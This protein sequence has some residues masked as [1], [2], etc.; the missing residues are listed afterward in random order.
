MFPSFSF[1][2]RHGTCRDCEML[3]CA[4]R[5]TEMHQN[6]IRHMF[7]FSRYLPWT[8]L[9]ETYIYISSCIFRCL[10]QESEKWTTWPS[11]RRI[12]CAIWT[13]Q[14]QWIY[15]WHLRSP[16]R[17]LREIDVG[18]FATRRGSRLM[19]PV[20]RCRLCRATRVNGQLPT[21]LGKLAARDGVLLVQGIF[22]GDGGSS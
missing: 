14:P 22:S 4:Q 20:I 5:I 21:L 12:S 13:A 18:S 15:Q 1:A 9:W 8:V 19:V 16:G 3:Q 7:S 6:M 17:R 2:I 10:H 11:S